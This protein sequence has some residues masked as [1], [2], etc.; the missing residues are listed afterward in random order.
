ML[1]IILIAA[2]LIG[3]LIFFKSINFFD[4]I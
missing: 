1:T 2:G 4:N 3:F